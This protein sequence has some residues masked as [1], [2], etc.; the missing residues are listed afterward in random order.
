MLGLPIPDRAAM[1]PTDCRRWLRSAPDTIRVFRGVQAED[2][3]Q[4]RAAALSGYQWTLDPEIAEWFARRFLSAGSMS[5]TGILPWIIQTDVRK[6]DII[7][8]LPERGEDEIVISP[9]D[10]MTG[11]TMRTYRVMLDD[12]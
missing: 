1:T 4:A 6:A 5:K 3:A 8:Y 10:V 2:P 9:G 12:E 7:A 11:P